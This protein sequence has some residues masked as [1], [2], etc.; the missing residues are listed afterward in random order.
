MYI[1]VTVDCVTD[2]LERFIGGCV[3]VS[4]ACVCGGSECL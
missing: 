4:M 1:Y 3:G 2:Q